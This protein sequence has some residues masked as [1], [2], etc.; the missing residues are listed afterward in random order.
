MTTTIYIPRRR[1]IAAW[2]AI[3]TFD[4]LA[5]LVILAIGTWNVWHDG[6]FHGTVEERLVNTW[7]LW[8]LIPAAIITVAAAFACIDN[9]KPEESER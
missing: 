4:V 5:V 7:L 9:V 6:P 1:F 2:A 3:I 8:G